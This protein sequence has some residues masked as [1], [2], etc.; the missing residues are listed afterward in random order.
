MQLSVNSFL[1]ADAGTRL[2]PKRLAQVAMSREQQPADSHVN[3]TEQVPVKE[4][5]NTTLEK[6][7]EAK[8]KPK[9]TPKLRKRCEHGKRKVHCR[10]CGGSAFCTHGKKKDYC[11]E[12][13]GSALCTHG[14]HKA[15]CRECGGSAFCTHGK[16]KA[17][18]RECGGSA[19]CTHR[20]QKT[21]CRECGGSAL[22]THGK[23]KACCR[24]CGGSRFCTHGKP[25]AHCR[26]CGGSALCTH[27]KLKACCRECGG[28]R[29][30]THGKPK[31]YCGECG[32][33]ALCTHGKHKPYC[34]ECGGSAFCTHGK[35]KACCKPCGGRYT[36]MHPFCENSTQKT[37]MV[38]VG[39]DPTVHVRQKSSERRMQAFLEKWASE[40]K[41]PLYVSNDKQFP[42]IVRSFCNGVKA[43]FWW[44]MGHW[45]LVLEND[46]MQHKRS[47]YDPRCDNIKFQDMHNALG[48]LPIYI[49]RLNPDAFK[50]NGITT[51]V[52][53]PCRM[54]TLLEVLQHVF[55]HPPCK[56]QF[57]IR[58]MFYNCS[59]CK[60]SNQCS[61][62]H[63]DK[64]KTM[65]LFADWIDKTYPLQS[66][67]ARKRLGPS[68][69]ARHY[70]FNE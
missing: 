64:F 1:M 11:R 33:S 6:I 58:Y 43:D 66:I 30:C 24:E 3:D 51:R 41:I 59:M 9:Q 47:S 19:L 8:Y 40:G 69:N 42:G 16:L 5:A 31:A 38:C 17:C 28:S 15:Y 46:E 35:L 26:E 50:V 68:A 62:E 60:N 36:C 7:S 37:N 14:K 25:K 39:C 34:R 70:Q 32:G 65:G 53:T 13:G 10:E 54:A 29:F 21:H 23:R 2:S 57:I 48:S 61:Y 20:K 52:S 18:C 44:D 55:E 4:K 45:A 27:G 67:G 22:C 63:V 56:H 49:I 12:C